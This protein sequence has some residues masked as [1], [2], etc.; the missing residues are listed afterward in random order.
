MKNK[1]TADAVT[2]TLVA[3][4]TRRLLDVQDHTKRS[5]ATPAPSWSKEPP[6]IA[7]IPR[8]RLRVRQR[9]PPLLPSICTAPTS[10][11]FPEPSTST[12]TSRP[13][14]MSV[15]STTSTMTLPS[16]QS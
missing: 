11:G 7:A 13:L 4:A 12:T 6:R 15:C 2:I 5:T 9:R 3:V 14:P 10:F 16:C 1:S 8:E